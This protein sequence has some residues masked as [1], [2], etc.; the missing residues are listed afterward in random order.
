MK[1]FSLIFYL[2]FFMI[3]GIAL[4]DTPERYGSHILALKMPSGLDEKKVNLGRML[5][6]E[7]KLS[8]DNSISCAHCHDLASGG[9]D[10]LPQSFGIN[11]A[12]GII[13]TPTVYNTVYNIAQFW[14]G[15]AKTLESQID[16]PV[17]DPVKMNSNWPDIIKKLADSADYVHRFRKIYGRKGLTESHI[18]DAIA[19]FERSLV[20]VNAPFDRFLAGD[21]EAISDD[22]KKGFELFRSYGCVSCHQGASVGGNMFQTMGVFGNYFEDRG[23]ITAADSGRFAVTGHPADKYK[24]KVPSLRLVTLT[25]PYFH[26]GSVD[27]LSAAIQIMARY[28]LG[29]EIPDDDIQ[30]IIAFLKTLK[31]ELQGG[32]SQ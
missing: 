3:S 21:H 26:D 22:A 14:N 13:N 4:A 29:R 27:N 9:V 20:T 32:G 16:E 6:H 2:T 8:A 12:K 17:H 10:G 25:A 15:R 30:L 1:Y 18:K 5:F 19:T 24:F 23:N 11:G 7:K 31:G 28:E